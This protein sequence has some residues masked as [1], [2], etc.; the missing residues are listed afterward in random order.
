M[1]FWKRLPKLLAALAVMAV[2]TPRFAPQGPPVFP[3][4]QGF[5]IHTRAGRGGTVVRVTTLAARGPGSLV[6][7]LAARGPR[8]I[9]FEVG[10][11][12]DLE[13]TIAVVTE[14]FVTV[15][16]Q[17][18][19]PPGITIIRGSL[20]IETHDV[21]VQHIRVRPGDAGEPTKDTWKPD[22]IS[23]FGPSAYNIV[24]DH[25]SVSWGVDENMSVS[26]P[27][28][29]GPSGTSHDV[30]FSNCIIAEG[31]LGAS[32]GDVVHSMG[33]LIHDY[34]RNVAI[35]GNLY[36]HNRKRAPYFK[37]GTT[38]VVVNN[39]IYNPGTKAI[40]ADDAVGGSAFGR[41]GSTNARL[42]VVGNVMIHGPATKPGLALVVGRGDVYVQDNI[43]ADARG[44]EVETL[45]SGLRRLGREP[46][47]PEGLVPIPA[48]AVLERVLA[49]AGA[50]PR[51]R[52]AVDARIV[53]E[54]R[55][56]T[57]RIIESQTD[58]GGYP[59]VPSTRRALEVPADGVEE[60]LAGLAAAV[61]VN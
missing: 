48:R 47:W 8:V 12:I 4:A 52:D 11:V 60:W 50:R 24:V 55:E 45:S 16:G 13:K 54:V 29:Q 27:N 22:G 51:D 46:I 39:V 19:P 1:T 20:S 25:C 7:A 3:G 18:G 10:G 31:L 5:G 26:G 35:I 56:G 37:G 32:R 23:T 44:R 59:V 38:G 36:A 40:G 17:T 28:N 53:R 49:T 21:L 30:T 15:A 2:P 42:A 6:E 33:S 58:V 9:V 41:L 34:C 43:T 61:E 14:P 57:G